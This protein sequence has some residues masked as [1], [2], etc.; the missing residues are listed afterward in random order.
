MWTQLLTIVPEIVSLLVGAVF[1]AE[2][3]Y[4]GATKGEIKKEYVMGVLRPMLKAKNLITG[5]DGESDNAIINIVSGAIDSFV[6]AVNYIGG[7]GGG[8]KLDFTPTD[9]PQKGGEEQ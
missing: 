9:V 6:G 7:F 1:D 4:K 3:L 5:G 2:K 8:E